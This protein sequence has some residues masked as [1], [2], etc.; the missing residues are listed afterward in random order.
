[1]LRVLFNLIL[2][3]SAG[4]FIGV[5]AF[6]LTEPFNVPA[7]DDDSA[8]RH[9]C[10]RE[11]PAR[12]TRTSTLELESGNRPFVITSKPR[13]EYTDLARANNIEGS[14]LLRV[15]LLAS[16]DVGQIKAIRELPDGLTEQ[17][18]EA[19]RQIEFEP[20]KINGR[21]VSIVKTFEYKFDIY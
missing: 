12:W 21:P 19:A 3:F 17:A 7:P 16:G 6:Y 5:G 4:C 8:M 18:I 13:A 20:K 1:M 15:S 9:S 2:P 14:V 10:R 11:R